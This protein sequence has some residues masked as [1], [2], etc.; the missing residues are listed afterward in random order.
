MRKLLIFTLLLCG[1]SS[2]PKTPPAPGDKPGL[3]P[4]TIDDHFVRGY[5]IMSEGRYAEA[6][7]QFNIAIAES[8]TGRG[9][10]KIWKNQPEAAWTD[11]EEALK[12]AP[13][14]AAHQGRGSILT[15]RKDFDGALK[16]YDQAIRIQ[17]D[18]AE[19]FF[20]RG[21]VY[22]FMGKPEDAKREIKKFMEL[23][24]NPT[25]AANA[26]KELDQLK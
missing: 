18:Y 2:A 3:G 11:F 13:V 16:E 6:E 25:W 15:G 14:A 20:G 22:K 12:L 7:A 21:M 24:K 9:M 5:A 23:N 19:P 8:Y 17:P 4:V 26:Q 1:C 10:C